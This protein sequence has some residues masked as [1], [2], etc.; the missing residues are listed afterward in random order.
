MHA[1]TSDLPSVRR[2][3]R[4]CISLHRQNLYQEP[5]G[6][7]NGQRLATVDKFVHLGST[8]SR[9]VHVD[10]EIHARTAKASS[11]FGRVRSSV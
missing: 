10:D 8:L 7:V 3:Q 9:S 5:T 11:A 2:K 1:A 4:L 6:A